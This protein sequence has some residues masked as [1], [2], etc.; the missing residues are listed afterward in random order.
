ML[1]DYIQA[2]FNSPMPNGEFLRVRTPTASQISYLNTIKV[3]YPIRNKA[4]TTNTHIIN[5]EFESDLK[6]EVF[7]MEFDLSTACDPDTIVTILP[8][9]YEVN[10]KHFMFKVNV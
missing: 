4:K 2:D 1:D 8:V 7:M 9:D 10:L 6:S 3:V 5:F